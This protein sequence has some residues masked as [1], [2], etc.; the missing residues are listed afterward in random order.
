MGAAKYVDCTRVSSLAIALRLRSNN[1]LRW[2]EAGLTKQSVSKTDFYKNVIDL[3]N[4][5]TKS[6]QFYSISCCWG[7]Y[8]Y[9]IKNFEQVL[10]AI[11]ERA[12][13]KVGGKYL[14]VHVLVKIDADNP[15]DVFA[16]DRLATVQGKLG[17]LT[18]EDGTTRPI[19]RELIEASTVQFLI[20]DGVRA[21]VSDQQH[22]RFNEDMGLVLNVSEDGLKFDKD[23][24]PAEFQRLLDMFNSGWLSGI[25]LQE[26]APRF[27]RRQ[28]RFVLEGYTGVQPATDERELQLMLTGYLKGQ[29]HQSIIDF[30]AMMVDTRID[31]LV[32]PKPHHTRSGIEIK[33]KPEDRHIDVIVGKLRNYRDN[34]GDLVLVV[35]APQFTP[36]GKQRL[37]LELR[38]LDVPMIEIK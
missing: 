34:Y 37:L 4:Q 17:K 20:T 5:A 38:T 8:S 24:D 10:S 6:V 15:M 22:E 32:G 12:K 14:D 36:K 9:G 31:L 26:K 18:G 28:L 25:D 1:A 3:V 19:F 23:D 35:G 13:L 11:R 33:F 30:E 27:T 21:L 16:A 7:F 29:V 2:E